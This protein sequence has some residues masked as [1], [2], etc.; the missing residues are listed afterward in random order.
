MRVSWLLIMGLLGVVFF[1]VPSLAQVGMVGSAVYDSGTNVL[2]LPSIGINGVFYR[3][4]TVK[5][6][7]Y[8]VLGVGRSSTCDPA[9]MSYVP[10]AP[11]PGCFSS[12]GVHNSLLNGSWVSQDGGVRLEYANGN[13]SGQLNE[14]WSVGRYLSPPL[15]ESEL[16]HKCI[17]AGAQSA[18]NVAEG[19]SSFSFDHIT[20]AEGEATTNNSLPYNLDHLTLSSSGELDR[21]DALYASWNGKGSIVLRRAEAW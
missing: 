20:C 15:Q 19:E 5:L 17:F 21:V 10:I 3:D 4:V 6:E 8:A 16:Y 2:T 7:S 1:P 11:T 13:I 14:F 12:V 18:F 9:N